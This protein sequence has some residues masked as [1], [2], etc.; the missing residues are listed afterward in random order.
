[1]KAMTRY[2]FPFLVLGW[3]LGIFGLT[4]TTDSAGGAAIQLAYGSSASPEFVDF[5]H[6]EK[7]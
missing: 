2:S 1:M 6:N 4:P 3:L 7:V 5:W